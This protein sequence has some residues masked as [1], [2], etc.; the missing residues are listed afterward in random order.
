MSK[1]IKC[2]C[3]EKKY[4]SK[5]RLYTHIENEHPEKISD[6][7][8]P[9]RL[10]FNR[11]NKK[12]KGTCVICGAETQW[13]EQ[14]RKYLRFCDEKCKAKYVDQAKGRMLNTYGKVH[15]LNDPKKQ[16]EMLQNRSISGDYKFSDGG[17]HGYTGSYERDFL[18]FLD[19]HMEFSSLDVVAPCPFTFY[20]TYEG[21]ELFY[22]PDIYIPSL[23]LIIEIKDGGD[24]PN[25]HPKIQ[26]VD[27]AK[28]KLKDEL[29]A[30]GKYNYL[31]ITN[32]DHFKFI[33]YLINLK[34]MDDNAKPYIKIHENYEYRANVIDNVTGSIISTVYLDKFFSESG[35]VKMPEKDVKVQLS[36]FKDCTIHIVE[37][38]NTQG[39]YET[40]CESMR[41]PET[42]ILVRTDKTILENVIMKMNEMSQNACEYISDVI[43]G[44]V[45]ETILEHEGAGMYCMN[46]NGEYYY[47]TEYLMTNPARSIQEV[48][49]EEVLIIN[50]K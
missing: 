18:E 42:P 39:I 25:N 22:I 11:D 13:N 37:N 35:V 40:L 41:N 28:E 50:M 10:V 15:L 3:C 46:S 8:T 5:E 38:D 49:K 45:T 4:E 6:S 2:P 47:R 29:M 26:A 7:M 16:R 23:N 48:S 36:S 1:K 21:K 24:N 17:V 20:Y 12:E 34:D 9:A 32:K 33:D 30:K 14:T 43:D 27:K 19:K 31:K 44:R